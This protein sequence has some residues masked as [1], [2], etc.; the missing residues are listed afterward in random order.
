MGRHASLILRQG[1]A[2]FVAY[3][4]IYGDLV[5]VEGAE[6]PG[7]VGLRPTVTYLDG[8]P[9]DGA[10]QAAPEGPR[11]GITTPGPDR[12]RYASATVDVKGRLDVAYYDADA[13]DL[14]YLRD[15]GHGRFE[16]PI[17]VD[18]DGD[19]G[20]FAHI[21]TDSRA[22]IHIVSHAARLPDGQTGLRYAF[23]LTADPTSPADFAVDTIAV[24]P[25]DKPT[26]PVAGEPPDGV[27][28]SPCLAIG[29]DDRPVVAFSTVSGPAAGRHKL[30]LAIQ[31]A[32]G[33]SVFPFYAGLGPGLSADP[34][35]RFADLAEH[36]LGAACDLAVRADG[37]ILLAF[38]DG[39]TQ[40]V[41][42]YEGPP[43]GGGLVDR[44]D[45]GDPGRVA[46]LGA[47]LALA[48]DGAGEPVL[49]YQDQAQ[50][51]LRLTRRASGEFLSPRA[52]ATAGALGFYNTLLVTGESA[53]VGTLELR[54]QAT[55]R[56]DLALHV[57]RADLPRP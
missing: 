3:D 9:A 44:V 23:S 5:L 57:F 36:D 42:L 7:G 21:E 32:Q 48:L 26:T 1:A 20:R 14:R 27:G 25:P 12:G 35:G 33:F 11:A 49:L 13:G 52:F 30:S 31:S 2:V 53:V 40:S 24:G 38:T 17:V 37:S 39:D 50:N 56:A 10:V 54:T 22:R 28:V 18:P 4:A 46:L 16:P 19:V 45:A 34:G 8:V 41:L 43:Q 29:P 47:D 6:D 51:D 55:G 15:D